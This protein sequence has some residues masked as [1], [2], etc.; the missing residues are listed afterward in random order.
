MLDWATPNWIEKPALGIPLIKVAIAKGGTLSIEERRGQAVKEREETA[1]DVL[2]RVPVNQRGWFSALMKA[3]QKAGYW[4]EDHTYFLDLY[5]AALGR[6]MTREIGRRFAEESVIRDPEDIY[7]LVADEIEKAM[8]PMGRVKLQHYADQRR[9]EW[10]GYLK[11][12]PKPFYGN[13]DLVQDM[14]KKDPVITVSTSAPV[15]R[16]GVKADLFSAASAPGIAEGIARVI[17]TEDKIGE[18]QPG[19]ILVAPGTSAQWTPVFEIIKGIITDGGGAL[20]HAVIVAR[21]Y[22]VPA[23]VGCL[24]ATRKIKTGDRVKLDGNLG[25]VFILERAGK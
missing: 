20:S 6:W 13:I 25:L 12:T 9:R 2:A 22:G 16:E 11:I 4:S 21:E 8:I 1:R 15:I 24:E 19:E 5:C 18:I 14:I 7:F 10:E 17:M 23:V 3:A